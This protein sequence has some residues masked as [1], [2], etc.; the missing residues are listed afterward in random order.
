MN[1]LKFALALLIFILP[2]RAQQSSEATPSS[3]SASGITMTILPKKS[4]INA[5]EHAFITVEIAN[6]SEKVLVLTYM[7]KMPS[8]RITIFDG[9]QKVPK[10]TEKGCRMHLSH[11]CLAGEGI[12][13]GSSQTVYVKPK[14]A[15]H[16]D[17]DVSDEYDLTKPGVYTV[18]ITQN[19]FVLIDA[20]KDVNLWR[21]SGYPSAKI[22]KIR[23]NSVEIQVVR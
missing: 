19:D 10:E 5:Q 9:Q 14:S 1:T 22:G 6:N 8:F 21:L 18:N 2:A 4:P 17:I 16:F 7:P 11:G 12:E 20:P 23:S 3:T 15:E 13:G